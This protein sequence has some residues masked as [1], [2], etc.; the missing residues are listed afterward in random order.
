MFGHDAPL[1]I[2]VW[3]CVFL[4]CFLSW[5]PGKGWRRKREGG[6]GKAWLKLGY[7]FAM[8]DLVL[9]WFRSNG[10]CMARV[11]LLLVLVLLL[12]AFL[13]FWLRMAAS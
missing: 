4:F 7:L 1:I 6:R 5:S 9:T 3:F 13:V 11:P 12:L 10:S 8:V 2:F